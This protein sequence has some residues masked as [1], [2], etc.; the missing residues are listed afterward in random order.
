ML[1]APFLKVG[2]TLE[3][4]V[5]GAMRGGGLGEGKGCWPHLTSLKVGEALEMKVS[6]AMRA[7]GGQGMLTAPFL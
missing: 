6:G 1:A 7:L 5:S 4:K 3:M 2:E